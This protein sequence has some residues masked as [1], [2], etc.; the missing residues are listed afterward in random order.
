MSHSV[1]LLHEAI[2]VARRLGYAVRAEALG[3]RGGGCRLRG[4]KWLFLDLA[5]GP[6]EQLAVLSEVLLRDEATARVPLSEPLRRHLAAERDRAE[7]AAARR[8]AG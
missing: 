8:A 3:G 6:I 1:L 7:D 4:A 2:G 5:D